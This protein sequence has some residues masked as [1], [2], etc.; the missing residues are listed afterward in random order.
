[1]ALGWGRVNEEKPVAMSE[2]YEA[3]TEVRGSMINVI[4]YR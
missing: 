4:P 1:M 2:Q 3:Q